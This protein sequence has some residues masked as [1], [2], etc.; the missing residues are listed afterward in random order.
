MAERIGFIGLGTMG[1]RMARRLLEAGHSVAGYDVDDAALEAFSGQGGRPAES[2]S[3]VLERTRVV[4]SSLPYSRT[5]VKVAEKELLPGARPGQT[6]IDLGTVEPPETRRLA[7]EF[8][9]RGAALLDAP[10]SGGPGGAESGT[11]RVFAGGRRETYERCLPLLEV[12]GDPDRIAYC[13]PSGCGQVTKAVNQLGM[14][15]ARA[16]MLECAAMGRLSGVDLSAVRRSVGG[17][18]GWR[19]I[20]AD[21]LDRIGEGQGRHVGV[22]SMQLGHFL[23][24][25]DER[26]YE[27]PITRAVHEFLKDAPRVVV[28]SNRESP[29]YWVELLKA[30][31]A[32]VD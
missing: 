22:K 29:S 32:D 1:G 8:E 17:D 12:L 7:A 3:E 21:T 10:V 18:S 4:M 5:W 13:G 31:G 11:L 24:E 23:S 19:R 25:A 6:F 30:G 16:V 15:L 26:G 14:G 2:T 9:E 20:L 27:M 28:E